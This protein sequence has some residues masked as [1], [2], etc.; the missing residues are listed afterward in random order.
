LDWYKAQLGVAQQNLV[1]HA[2]N[3]RTNTANMVSDFCEENEI[4][5]ARHPPYSPDLAPSDFYFFGFL[6][7]RLKGSVCDESDELRGAIAAFLEDVERN[8]LERVFRHWMKKPQDCIS[9]NGEYTSSS[10][11]V[12][13]EELTFG[14]TP[15]KST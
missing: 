13:V 3:A 7:D 11:S 1:I 6:K 4:T 12:D 5:V 15:E 14:G 8:S 9:G 10:Y 2:H